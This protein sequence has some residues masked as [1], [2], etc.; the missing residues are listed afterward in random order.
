MLSN[1]A[2]VKESPSQ[3]SKHEEYQ[4]LQND[5]TQRNF[6]NR[7]FPDRLLPPISLLYDGFGVFADVRRGFPVPGEDDIL[8]NTLRVNVNKF[9]WEM[10]RFFG[11]EAMR[12]DTVISHLNVIFGTRKNPGIVRDVIAGKFCPRDISSDG[13]MNGQH[14]TIMFCFE[15]KNEQSGVSCNPSAQLV[16]YIASSFHELSKGEHRA[17]LDTWRLPAL[18]M[19]LVGELPL[20]ASRLCFLTGFRPLRSILRDRHALA[21]HAGRS[22]DAS[23]ASRDLTG[24]R[25]F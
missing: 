10:G 3:I 2:I 1:L 12:R 4:K 8:E 7:P 20:L 24:G 14:K 17:L 13:H 18:G 19:T 25:R 5:S 22:L 23:A 6:D 11:T 16:S 9:V 21:A 15:C